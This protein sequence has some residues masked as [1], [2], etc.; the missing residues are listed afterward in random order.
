MKSLHV[1][2]TMCIVLDIGVEKFLKKTNDAD[3]MENA[4]VPEPNKITNTI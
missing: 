3:K 2:F 4:W 1:F